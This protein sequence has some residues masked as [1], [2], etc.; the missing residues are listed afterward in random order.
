[1]V[2]YVP[3]VND[4]ASV[5]VSLCDLPDDIL[6]E[7]IGTDKSL[8]FDIMTSFIMCHARACTCAALQCSSICVCID[9]RQE[10]TSR[11]EEGQTECKVL[12][13]VCN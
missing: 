11:G 2:F 9:L 6:H 12:Q 1:M 3:H 13:L 7:K 4:L 8:R 5:H 10:N